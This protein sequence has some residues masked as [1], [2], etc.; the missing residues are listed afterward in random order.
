[1]GAVSARE[2]G[3]LPSGRNLTGGNGRDLL[4]GGAGD[5]TIIGNGGNDYM[6]GGAGRDRFVLNPGGGWDCIGDF[7]AGSGG[8]ML[9]LGNWKA[10][11]G[12][13]NLLASS[14]QDSDGLVLEFSATDSVKLMG[15]TAGMLTADNILF[16]GAAGR[17]IAGGA[18][19]DL[20]FGGAGDD[21]ITGNGGNDYMEGGTGRDRFILNPGDGWDCVGDF[22]VGNGGDVLDLRGWNGIGGFAELLA[23]SHQDPDG[24]VLTFGPTD[25]VKLMG[26][27]RNMLTADNV[28]LG[29]DGPARATAVFIAHDEQHGD[30][31]WGSD[32]TRAFLLRDIAAGPAGSEIIGPVSAGGRVF[33]SA[34]DGV[35][36]RELWMSDGTTAGTRM[37]SDIVAGS[38]GSNPLAMTAFGDRVLF[39]ADDGVHGT[40]LWVSDGTAAG[41]HLL[42]DI[43]AG[44]TSSNPG[45]FTQLGDNVYFSARD[46]EH[47][48]ALWKTDGTAAGTVMV[49]DF[50][51]GNQDP[52]VMVIIQPSHL[53]AADDR[54]YLTAWDGTDGFTQL[55]V[56]D[57]TE[58]GTTKLRGDLTD[59]PQFGLDLEIGAVGKQLYFND[60]VNLW[61]SDGTVAGTRE[62]RHNYPDV[63]ARPQQFTAA[64]DTMYYVNYDRH[65]GYEVMA[66]DDSGS[67]GRFLGDFNPGPNSSRPFELTAVGDTM[68]FAADDGTTTTLWQS[69]GH[70]WDTRKVVDAGGDDS[71][72][73]VT[74]LSA[75][76]GDL[77]FSA[78]DQSQVDAMFRLDTGSGE[79]TRLAG[80][81]G[82]PL[83]GPTVV[84]M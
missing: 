80:S 49:K 70:S 61:T 45:S 56:T 4:F 33:F 24:L 79:V 50:L 16:A 23:G 41:T 25:S 32:G 44:A 74:N 77:Y 30:E 6:E 78:K 84:A 21:T 28:L 48:V 19:R 1:M 17:R 63:Y 69:G 55:W 36:G 14:H 66:T 7:Q 73:S 40:E 38:G 8:D 53:T 34:D 57:G 47:G 15:V 42:K 52:P 20:L 54:L 18:A 31:L 81:Y 62:V 27:T 5:D 46:A 72:S 29:N 12:L 3:F 2:N 13:S 67:E 26:V 82:L 60:D 37:V 51:P 76:G 71:W 39:Q 83:G 65:T 58:A 35:H 43:Y 64:G 22:K 11:G 68:Y 9:D 10:I 59:L 75:V